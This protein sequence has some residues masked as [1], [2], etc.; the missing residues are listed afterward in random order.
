MH[1][2]QVGLNQTNTIFHM[3]RYVASADIVTSRNC[4][5]LTLCGT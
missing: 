1:D 3:T 4:S 5:L 2:N